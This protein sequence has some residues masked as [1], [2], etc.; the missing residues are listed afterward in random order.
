MLDQKNMVDKRKK[1]KKNA[2]GI[3]HKIRRATPVLPSL[4][5][6]RQHFSQQILPSVH[7]SAISRNSE[8]L[9]SI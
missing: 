8:I 4:V 1:K 3:K 2:I 7:K 5:K 9:P 6:R